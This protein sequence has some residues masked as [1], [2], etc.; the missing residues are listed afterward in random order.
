M[1]S[2]LTEIIAAHR[3]AAAR[4]DRDPAELEAQAM[5][6]RS[7]RPFRAALAGADATGLAVIAEVKRRSPS[8]GDL[9]PDLDPSEVAR[10]YAAGG[11]T[12][13]SVLT[14]AAYFGGAPQDLDA[15]RSSSGLPV[16]RKDFTVSRA[17]VCDARLMGADAVLLI[18]AALS[19]EELAEFSAL[20][21]RLSLD[22][23]VEVHDDAELARSLDLGADLIGVNQRDLVTFS[24]DR[25]RAERLA[26]SIPET[27]VAVAESGV[28]D[29]ADAER[30][31]AAGYQGVLV[32]ESVVAAGDRTAAVRALAGHRVG[33]RTSLAAR[34]SGRM[35]R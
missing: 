4:D 6:V 29:R 15:A 17:D 27:V 32:G 20:A 11:A 31:A 8:A 33:R 12:A 25:Q 35:P 19:D 30:L 18:A 3:A 21:A 2:Y 23:L 9:A 28:R 24:V 10:A 16:L 5:G 1:P 26:A 34:V 7:P 13:L 22:V 14:D